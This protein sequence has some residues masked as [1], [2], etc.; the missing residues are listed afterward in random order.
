[1]R[2]AGAGSSAAGRVAREAWAAARDGWDATP[3]AARRS[4]L[5][6]LGVAAAACVA[7]SVG[8]ALLLEAAAGTAALPG[9]ARWDARLDGLMG[10]H[11]ALWLGAFTSS[12]MV[13]PMLLAVAVLAARAARWERATLV[14]VSY[15]ASKAIILAGWLTWARARPADVAGGLV[16]PES[17]AS[18][19]SG[20]T[21]QAVGIYGLL[22]L[23]WASSTD[24]RWE[25]ALAWGGVVALVVLVGVARVRVGAHYPSDVVGGAAL[26][27]L[28]LAGMA[29][30]ERAVRRP[31]A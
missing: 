2:G 26:G 21:V 9:E 6:R 5:V 3:P 29:W 10:V 1:M 27:A 15:L 19:P 4:F 17:M 28:W 24:R 22:A 13:T 11:S 7:A 18:F 14:L 16:V 25:K 23:W 8:S 30:A 20:H 31:S 12:A